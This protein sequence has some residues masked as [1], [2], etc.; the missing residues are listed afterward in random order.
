MKH[1]RLELL[2]TSF[3]ENIAINSVV[4]SFKTTDPN[5]GDTFVIH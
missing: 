3:D 4:S 2:T 1:S 5:P